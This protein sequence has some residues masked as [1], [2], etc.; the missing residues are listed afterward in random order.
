MHNSTSEAK[1]SSSLTSN[2][3]Q[4]FVYLFSLLDWLSQD[5]PKKVDVEGENVEYTAD[6]ADEN[7]Q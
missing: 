5:S 7:V 3:L 6:N 2:C 1:C 4:E